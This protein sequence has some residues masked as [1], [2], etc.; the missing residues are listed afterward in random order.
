MT[1]EHDTDAP[2]EPTTEDRIEY[3]L[4]DPYAPGQYDPEVDDVDDPDEIANLEKIQE[5][6]HRRERMTERDSSKFYEGDPDPV[7]DAD[8]L[9]LDDPEDDFDPAEAAHDLE[10]DRRI[11]ERLAA[12]GDSPAQD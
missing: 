10:V 12:E 1:A 6:R 9:A 8:L 2:S 7:T 3:P 11:A 5:M 4:L